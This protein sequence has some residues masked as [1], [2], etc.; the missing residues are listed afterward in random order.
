MGE[1]APLHNRGMSS[2]AKKSLVELVLWDVILAGVAAFLLFVDARL[3]AEARALPAP[4]GPEAA[5]SP[6]GDSPP[7][8]GGDEG[9]GPARVDG[10][11]AE[12]EAELE[13][14]QAQAKGQPA[15]EALQ[16][17]E[18]ASA[19]LRASAAWR[20]FWPLERERLQRS[21]EEEALI[22]WLGRG[23]EV[24]ADLG[25]SARARELV[26]A[27]PAA[28]QGRYQGELDWAQ[29][30]AE[31]KATPAGQ[32]GGGLKLSGGYDPKQ[33]RAEGSRCV[34]ECGLGQQE[35]ERLR[36]A[37]EDALVMLEA[38][39]G[40]R[41]ASA[42]RVAVLADAAQPAPK[43][44]DVLSRARPGEAPAAR[45]ER[46]AWLAA[47][48]GARQLFP[49]AER[50]TRAAL[51]E[52]L[53][54]SVQRAGSAPGLNALGQAQASL[55]ELPEGSGS[56][57]GALA[58]EGPG[59][60]PARRALAL[61]LVRFALAERDQAAIELWPALLDDARGAKP[62]SAWMTPTRAAGLEAAWRAASEDRR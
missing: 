21:V 50:W 27:L 9:G 15:G 42:C 44:Y 46:V 30:Q 61:G 36:G 39:A 54:G 3:A 4:P 52:V 37:A 12:L 18:G 24:A 22:R 62:L 55:L 58:S 53:A 17:Y 43:S 26:A 23:V 25:R 11:E 60:R 51:I 13:R 14:L 40:R 16:T 1:G 6:A 38:L 34:V 29:A 7:S 45:A 59:A 28:A 33:G 49:G 5:A 48:W 41:P 8:E 2:G 10:R 19:A 31:R 47:D 32:G 57:L 56:E 20:R 35:A